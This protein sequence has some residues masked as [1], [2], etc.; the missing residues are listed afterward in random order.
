MVTGQ[1][2]F[3]ILIGLAAVGGAV[4]VARHR[5]TASRYLQKAARRNLIFGRRMAE[6]NARNQT[7]GFMWFFAFAL[8]CWG[9]GMVFVGLTGST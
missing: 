1:R 4:W 5:Q 6:E 9:V 2:L 7:P 8:L 3:D